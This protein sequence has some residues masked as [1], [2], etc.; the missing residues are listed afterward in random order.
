[1]EPHVQKRKVE[2]VTPIKSP[3]RKTA[4]PI[5]GGTQLQVA[6]F[7]HASPEA[8][9]QRWRDFTQLPKFMTHIQTV[10]VIDEKHSHWVVVGPGNSTVE[11]NAEIIEDIP[12]ERISWR[13]VE[14]SQVDIAGS[15]RFEPARGQATNIEVTLTY[16][17]PLGP[18]GETLAGLFGEKPETQLKEDLARFKEAMEGARA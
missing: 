1:M 14:N 11:W 6:L 3:H 7:V 18:L 13:S 17:P 12:H 2:G 9:Y 15:V 4:P 8:C 5:M 16:N 10:K